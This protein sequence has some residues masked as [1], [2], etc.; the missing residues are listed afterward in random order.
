MRQRRSLAGERFHEHQ[1]AIRTG[2][3][4]LDQQE[5]LVRIDPDD[6][7][8]LLGNLFRAHVARLAGAFED[9][10]GVS[11]TAALRLAV[12]H[13]AVGHVAAMKMEALD[14][15]SKTLTFGDAGDADFVT[16]GKGIGLE[17]V[18]SGVGLAFGE[19]DLGEMAYGGYTLLDEVDPS[20]L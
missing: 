8:P 5:V 7:Q 16:Y 6:S 20:R 9:V 3:S 10:G 15:T 14:H 11:G 2:H 4:A 12:N 19:P 1:A 17:L 13:G 18:T